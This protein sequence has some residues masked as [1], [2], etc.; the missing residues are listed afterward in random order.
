ML[1]LLV[2]GVSAAHGLRARAARI[3]RFAGDGASCLWTACGEG[4]LSTHLEL[5]D[6]SEVAVDARGDVYIADG[7]NSVV[8][9]VSPYSKTARFAG[10]EIP[11]AHAPRSGDGGPAR[12]AELENS[13]AVG[14]GTHGEVYIADHG[15]SEVREVSLSGTISRLAGTG[16]PFCQTANRCGDDER[17]ITARLN[18]PTGV[19]VDQAD[20]ACIAD[21]ADHEVRKIS[22]NGTISR[23]TGTGRQCGFSQRCSDGRPATDAELFFPAGVAA[24]R[25]GNVYIADGDSDKV[26][27]VAPDGTI[28]RFAGDGRLCF[29]VR[30]CG[31]GLPA[32]SAGLAIPFGVAVDGS[33]SVYIIDFEL[34]DVRRVSPSGTVTRV[35]GNGSRCM[36]APGCRDGGPAA[37]GE[38]NGPEGIAVDAAMN[39][40]IADSGDQ[41]VR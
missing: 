34:S 19:T 26:R 22:P 16:R 36:S 29:S 8:W 13:V 1:S 24:D 14:I 33:G 32:T 18:Q 30:L 38:L 27:E 3:T 41:E 7:R 40:Y 15:A 37:S 21:Y 11:C 35:V 39:V 10:T 23:F 28:S 2:V 31:D 6:P 17:A 9:R 25:S 12:E 5:H 4:S 20:D